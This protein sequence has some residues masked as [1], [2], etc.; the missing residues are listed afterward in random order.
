MQ[1]S[2][3]SK[4]ISNG[5]LR[6]MPKIVIK[7]RTTDVFIT[8]NSNITRLDRIAADMYQDDTLYWLI[9]L[10]NPQFYS[11]FD[12]PHRT[13]IR[14]PMPLNEVMAEFQTKV[15]ENQTT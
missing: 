14:V 2:R 11:E 15:I 1:F 10:A 3:Y 7:N 12:I 5:T 6:S 9:L 13:V 4:L 8:Y